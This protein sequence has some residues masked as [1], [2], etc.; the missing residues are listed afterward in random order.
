MRPL[1][2][3]LIRPGSTAVLTME[4]QRGIVGAS[5]LLPA[6]ADQVAEAGTLARVAQLLD[7]AR[8]VGVPVVH[9][10]VARRA[11]GR[12]ARSNAPVL[13]RADAAA[14]NNLVIGTES[15]QVMPE[16]GPHPS[17]IVVERHH[18]VTPFTGT[19]LDAVLRGLYVDSVVLVGVSLNMG[20]PGATM[21]AIGLGYS[22]V[23][24]TDAVAGVPVA[25]A[26]DV[27]RNSLRLLATL[28]TVQEIVSSWAGSPI[29]AIR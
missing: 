11:D 16:L 29:E 10:T 20:I 13:Q 7:A 26:A 12:G 28:C 27:V 8:A 1:P 14:N 22:V 3:E 19:S 4:L 6:L 23:I 5:A 15:A 17:D 21:E 2:T 24:P 25:Y 18:G 9:A